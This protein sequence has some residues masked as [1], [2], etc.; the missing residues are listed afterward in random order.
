MNTKT[1]AP[2]D[3]KEAKRL[4]DEAMRHEGVVPG[5]P[6]PE[7]FDNPP[8]G[9]RGHLC[10]DPQGN[11]RPRWSCIKIHK[12]DEN[13]PSYQFFNMNG[14]KRK[15]K[16]GIWVDVPPFIVTL[17]DDCEEEVISMDIEKSNPLIH[18]HVPMVVDKHPRFSFSCNPS[19]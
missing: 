16:L 4:A 18:D 11:Y 2:I 7:D 6:L 19:A 17:L 9:D 13:A 14:M 10:L 5:K 8:L 1:G 12:M 3:V 15:V